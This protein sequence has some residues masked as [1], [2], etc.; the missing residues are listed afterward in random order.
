MS[1][2]DHKLRNQTDP[3][4]TLLEQDENFLNENYEMFHEVQKPHKTRRF[5]HFAF[6][7]ISPNFTAITHQ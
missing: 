1:K 6:H 4:L 2:K 5:E 7:G 3:E